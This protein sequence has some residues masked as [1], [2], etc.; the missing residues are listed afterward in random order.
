[1]MEVV[2]T[3]I[4]GIINSNS[5]SDPSSQASKFSNTRIMLQRNQKIVFVLVVII[6]ILLDMILKIYNS[7]ENKIC[8]G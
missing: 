5:D 8:K 7:G 4:P 3:E 2:A 1:M 6:L